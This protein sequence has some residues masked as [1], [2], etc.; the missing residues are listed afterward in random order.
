MI[1]RGRDT[2]PTNHP[3]FAFA[4]NTVLHEPTIGALEWWIQFG[5][6]SALTNE[7]RM[8]TYF[9]MMANSR[10]VEWLQNLT[11]PSEIR[12]A[13]KTW[14]KR[15][16]ATVDELWRACL[17]VKEGENSAAG[18]PAPATTLEDEQQLDMLWSDLI[19]AAGALHMKPDDLKTCTRSVLVD[20]MIQASLF[21]RVPMKKS[22]AQDY[23]AYRQVM[24]QIEDRA[25]EN[26]K[27]QKENG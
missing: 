14:K 19:V 23:I 15:V 26:K 11:S 2:T 3:R 6:D 8:L 17:Y 12:K 27:E 4:G 24:K 1:E 7:G 13:V 9:F 25:A 21:A 18:K 16:G 22:I 20:M 10:H 5:K